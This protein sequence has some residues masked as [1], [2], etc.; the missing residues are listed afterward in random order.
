LLP[1]LFLIEIY[2]ML[3]TFPYIKRDS[4]IHRLDPRTK[5]V[6]LLAFSFSMYQTINIWVMVFGLVIASFYYSQAH[7][8]W[9]E[10]KQAWRFLITLIV[11]IVGAN[12]ILSS[13]NIVPGLEPSQ[14]HIL[15]NIPFIGFKRQVPYIGPAP[16]ILSIENITLMLAQAM[17]NSSIAL[18][19]VPIS[20]TTN[21]GHLGVAFNGLGVSD[22]IS[23][24]IDL[25][26]R[27]LPT[28]ARDF[29]VTLDAQRA[30]GFELDKLRGGIFTKAARLAPMLVP[31]VIGSIVGAEDI[32]SAMEL[33]CFGIGKRS[34]LT[35]LR[36]RPIDRTIIVLSLSGF[37]IITFLNIL[38]Y[39]YTQGPLHLLHTQGIPHFLVP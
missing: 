3:I 26:L 25:S 36:A 17:R 4:P 12:Y 14:Q 33:R 22:R 35:E 23:Y 21:P 18:L 27:F 1:T 20:Y 6:L 38:G 31:V 32:I 9:S 39:F 8:K 13:G 29:S 2:S 10:T 11:I 19:A 24:A 16:L 30:R 28:L 34:W 37:A 15:Y 7:L 5:L